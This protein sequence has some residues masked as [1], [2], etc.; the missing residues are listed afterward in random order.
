M[1]YFFKIA[2][3]RKQKEKSS[4]RWVRTLHISKTTAVNECEFKY[5]CFFLLKFKLPIY[6]LRRTLTGYPV[7]LLVHAHFRPDSTTFLYF[8]VSV[9]HNFVHKREE[10]KLLIF[11]TNDRPIIP[12]NTICIFLLL[13]K[14]QET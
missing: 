1:S 5:I 7:A 9:Q 4:Q 6:L 14:R 12:A 13:T 8:F 11:W 2:Q 10:I 3:K